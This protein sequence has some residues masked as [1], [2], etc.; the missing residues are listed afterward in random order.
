MDSRSN[1]FLFFGR[2][3]FLFG[4]FLVKNVFFSAFLEGKGYKSVSPLYS[5][6]GNAFFELS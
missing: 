3:I 5:H 4:D 2:Q 1:I 6:L